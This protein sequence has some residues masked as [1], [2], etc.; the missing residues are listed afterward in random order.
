MA[1]AVNP[2]TLPGISI[3]SAIGS[4]AEWLQQITVRVSGPQ[5]SH[6]SGVIW[7]SE[8]LVITNAHVARA[9]QHEI[10]LADGRK[11]EAWLLARDAKKDLAAL[12]ISGHDFPSASV[13]SARTLRAGEMLI[14]VGNPW[15]GAGAV[16]VGMA[17]RQV[18]DSPW[19]IAD[20]RLAPGNS[21]GAMADA[22]GQV[23]GVSSMIIDGFGVAVTSDTV[24]AFLRTVRLTERQ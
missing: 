7:R 19:L 9:D 16:S 6:G 13:R 17:H 3:G 24:E 22:Q 12:A 10:E 14:A 2:I 20:I 15:D 23:V 18:G 4:V 21:G 8:G 5:N 1:A 11:F